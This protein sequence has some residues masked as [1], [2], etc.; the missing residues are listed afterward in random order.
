MRICICLWTIPGQE[1]YE[2]AKRLPP[3]TRRD[4]VTSVINNSLTKVAHSA[5]A[6]VQ[7][8]LLLLLLPLLLVLFLL[9]LMLLLLLLLLLLRRLA[10][11][12]R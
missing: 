7:V 11:G 12:T 5:A 8:L 1:C 2:D 6:A 10:A 3:G 4:A 9:V